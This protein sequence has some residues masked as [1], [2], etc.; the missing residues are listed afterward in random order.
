MI[1]RVLYWLFRSTRNK[2][3]LRVTKVIPA[4]ISTRLAFW[5]NF[6]YDKLLALLGHSTWRRPLGYAYVL[7]QVSSLSGTLLDVGCTGSYLHAELI[8]RG[9]K[10]YGIDIRDFPKRH[11][12]LVFINE[13]ICQNS[14]PSNFF[15]TVIAVS[16]IEHVGLGAFGDPIL[17][18]G[19]KIA[20]KETLRVLK[21]NGIA[22]IT[23]PYSNKAFLDWEKHYDEVALDHLFGPFA[24]DASVIDKRK[25]VECSSSSITSGIVLLTIKKSTSQVNTLRVHTGCPIVG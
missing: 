3:G 9:F 12:N 13:D 4:T 17:A 25:W 20:L 2:L 8:A 21:E 22:V 6:Y 10:V 1:R 18:K 7:K 5:Y 14:L 19:D 16:S 11:P 15:E 23:L 24:R